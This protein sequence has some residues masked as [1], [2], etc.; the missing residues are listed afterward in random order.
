MGKLRC[1]RPAGGRDDLRGQPFTVADGDLFTMPTRGMRLDLS[2]MP[3]LPPPRCASLRGG[4]CRRAGAGEL[5]VRRNDEGRIDD[6]APLSSSP[7]RPYAAAF[8]GA[9]R[10]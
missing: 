4:R 9:K 1:R 3:N 6:P 10:P 2:A 7:G 5:T 8:F